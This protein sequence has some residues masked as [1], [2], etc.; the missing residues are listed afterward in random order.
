MLSSHCYPLLAKSTQPPIPYWMQKIIADFFRLLYHSMLATPLAFDCSANEMS[1]ALLELPSFVANI[2]VARRGPSL[3]G[4]YSWYL[5]IVSDVSME[6]TLSS[7][8]CYGQD[9]KG[10]GAAVYVTE[11]NPHSLNYGLLMSFPS[12]YGSAYLLIQVSVASGSLDRSTSTFNS[13]RIV[14]HR[15]VGETPLLFKLFDILTGR[16]GR[17]Q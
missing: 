11:I 14:H 16:N 3:E 5:A 6:S 9:L 12:W 13:L 4:A 10:V 17:C 1:S 2:A 8:E 7:L 15:F